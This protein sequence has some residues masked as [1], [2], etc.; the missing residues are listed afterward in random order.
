MQIE[1]DLG[2]LGLSLSKNKILKGQIDNTFL[3]TRLL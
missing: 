1:E 2:L 3:R